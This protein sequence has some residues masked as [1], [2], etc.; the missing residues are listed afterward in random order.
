MSVGKSKVITLVVRY[1]ENGQDS[2]GLPFLEPEVR[3]LSDEVEGEA[4][5]QFT[6]RSH[7]FKRG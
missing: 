4:V 5:G 6:I 1:K 7:N 3:Y 2:F